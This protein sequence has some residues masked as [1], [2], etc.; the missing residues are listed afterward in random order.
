MGNLHYSKFIVLAILLVL[1]GSHFAGAQTYP[2]EKSLYHSFDRY[3]F[4]YN[5][6][7]CIIVTPRITAE[8]TPWIWRARFF[9][10]EPQVDL[11]L[12]DKGFHLVYADVAIFLAH[13]KPSKYGTGFMSI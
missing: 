1:F 10:H 9:T 2:G 4:T 12:L 5:D 8:G 7:A 3:D 11:A 6:R 13:H